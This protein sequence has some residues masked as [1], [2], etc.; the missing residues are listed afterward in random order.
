MPTFIRSAL[1]R[2]VEGLG[3]GLAIAIVTLAVIWVANR[4][5]LNP[6]EAIFVVSAPSNNNCTANQDGWNC[7]AMVTCPESDEVVVSGECIV[8]NGED[9]SD[10]IRYQI[11][12]MNFGVSLSNGKRVTSGSMSDPD[13]FY[14]VWTANKSYPNFTPQVGAICVKKSQFRFALASI[15]RISELLEGRQ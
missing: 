11:S 6:D 4:Y 2:F 7:L 13:S 14:C 8:A 1:D 15:K 5:I 3:S 12:L 9:K 10:K